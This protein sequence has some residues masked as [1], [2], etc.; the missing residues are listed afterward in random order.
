MVKLFIRKRYVAGLDMYQ[1]VI[2]FGSKSKR[3]RFIRDNLRG[4]LHCIIDFL[5]HCAH[6]IA[7]NFSGREILIDFSWLSESVEDEQKEQEER[8]IRVFL[9]K[10]ILDAS[11]G[12]LK[13]YLVSM[14]IEKDGVKEKLKTEE[15]IEN[16]I[17]ALIHFLTS[18]NQLFFE[19][20]HPIRIIFEK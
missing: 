14:E 20:G 17:Q 15:I 19:E 7:H 4:P 2:I 9:D 16:P 8:V 11:Q 12:N 10:T 5:I 3:K 18:K 13:P 1:A 6:P